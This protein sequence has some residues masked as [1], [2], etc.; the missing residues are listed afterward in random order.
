MKEKKEISL[1]GENQANVLNNGGQVGSDT[2]KN[3]TSMQPH[4]RACESQETCRKSSQG[5]SPKISEVKDRIRAK[6]KGADESKNRKLN[7]QAWLPTSSLMAMKATNSRQ[8]QA[9]KQNQ[10]HTNE[11]KQVCCE[12]TPFWEKTADTGG[13]V[14]VWMKT[15]ENFKQTKAKWREPQVTSTA[16]RWDTSQGGLR[17]VWP[18]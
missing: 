5:G 16:R 18:I 3:V 12:K 9:E 14:R 10:E 2:L 8:Y 11:Y 17:K 7:T 13:R 4:K 15:K 6:P 1:V